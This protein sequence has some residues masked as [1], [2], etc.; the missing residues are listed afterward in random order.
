M[1]SGTCRRTP[2]SD[3]KER[4]QRWRRGKESAAN[5]EGLPAVGEVGERQSVAR[6]DEARAGLPGKLWRRGKRE[7]GGAREERG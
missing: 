4:K 3:G 1:E 2:I 7:D 6:I 5:Q